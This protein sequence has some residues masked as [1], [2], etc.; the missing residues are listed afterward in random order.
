M[1]N[2][3][4]HEVYPAKL[5]RLTTLSLLR[6]PRLLPTSPHN[7]R[8][9]RKLLQKGRREKRWQLKI[10]KET[11]NPKQTH[12]MGSRAKVVTRTTPFRF[13]HFSTPPS[14]LAFNIRSLAC[15]IW[16]VHAGRRSPRAPS[17]RG[18]IAS[19]QFLH[20]QGKHGALGPP[21]L[22]PSMSMSSPVDDRLL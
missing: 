10:Q 6:C 14:S 22:L 4:D 15:G 11:E 7:T 1:G 3:N 16:C 21:C 2:T 13:K 5:P 18:G 19:Y 17:S 20:G 8:L 9:L 12:W